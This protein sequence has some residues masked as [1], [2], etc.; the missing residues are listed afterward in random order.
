MFF[1]VSGYANAEIHRSCII[2]VIF[3]VHAESPNLDSDL[4]FLKKKIEAGAS[5]IVTQMF[6]DNQKYFDFVKRCREKGITVPIIPGLKP[7]SV[8]NHLTSIPKTFNVD[9]P[10]DLV[11]EIIKCKDN[12]QV[13]ELGVEWAINQSKELI[14]AGVPVLHIYTMGKTD[15]VQKIAKAVF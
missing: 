12:K 2:K 10:V 3:Q 7:V 1:G 8:K 5:Y 6:F 15:N 13:R 9:M 4:F 11:K 14:A